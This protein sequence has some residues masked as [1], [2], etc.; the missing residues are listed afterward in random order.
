MSKRRPPKYGTRHQRILSLIEDGECGLLPL[1]F[2]C[3]CPRRG[4]PAH[5]HPEHPGRV[6]YL[7]CSGCRHNNDLYFTNRVCI[8]PQARRVAA[9]WLAEAITA[10]AEEQQEAT[11]E[12]PSLF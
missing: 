1:D 8:H 11:G 4:G 7:T 9:R 5:P 3:P 12:Q 2:S 10:W 6:G